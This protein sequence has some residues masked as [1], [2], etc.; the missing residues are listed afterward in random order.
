MWWKLV[1]W[2]WVLK[3]LYESW[4]NETPYTKGLL[5]SLPYKLSRTDKL[6]MAGDPLS[7]DVYSIRSLTT[8]TTTTV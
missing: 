6:S 1:V 3:E 4:L 8:I 5:L 2:A 7:W